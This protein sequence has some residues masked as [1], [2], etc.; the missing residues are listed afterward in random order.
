MVHGM[1][2]LH[3]GGVAEWESQ[4]EWVAECGG[5]GVRGLQCVGVAVCGDCGLRGLHQEYL[6]FW[7]LQCGEIWHVCVRICG[8]CRLWGLLYV[9]VLVFGGC[10]AQGLQCVGVVVCGSYG[11]REL[12]SA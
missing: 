7:G 10:S 3:R 2:G 1:L 12:Q 4:F 6:Q 11:V 9:V 8:I 5:C